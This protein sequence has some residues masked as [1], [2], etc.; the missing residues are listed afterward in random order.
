MKKI[1]LAACA[2]FVISAVLVD[3][4]R[5]VKVFTTEFNAVYLEDCDDAEFVETAKQRKCS[6]CHFGKKKKDLNAYGV[7]IG[8]LL[9]EDHY[10]SRRVREEPEKV[11]QEVREALKK[12]ES[13]KTPCGLTWG[14]LLKSGKL[15]DDKLAEDETADDKLPEDKLP[16]DDPVEPAE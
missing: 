15:P 2:G 3:S 14:E 16:E 9:D 7:A 10:K 12:A 13:M 4:A 1:C 6:V 8:T 5:A 11:S